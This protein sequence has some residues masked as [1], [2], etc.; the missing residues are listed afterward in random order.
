MDFAVDLPVGLLNLVVWVIWIFYDIGA[1]LFELNG[2]FVV[3]DLVDDEFVVPETDEPDL[4]LVFLVGCIL[5]IHVEYL[6]DAGLYVA[7]ELDLKALPVR[8]LHIQMRIVIVAAH[9]VPT[10]DVWFRVLIN[11]ANDLVPELTELP[12]D[13]EVAKVFDDVVHLPVNEQNHPAV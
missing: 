1:I 4:V 3:L 5:Y 13:V 6:N 11:E 10:I 2:L 8:V 9:H 7:L 12:L